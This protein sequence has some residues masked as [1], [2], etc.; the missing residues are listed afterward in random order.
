MRHIALP[1]PGDDEQLKRIAADVME[2]PLDRSRPL[3]E[4]WVI[5]GLSGN[6]FAILTKTHHCMVDGA[7]GM[8]LMEYMFSLSADAE[9][10][11]APRFVP[12]PAP[13]PGV[14]RRAARRRRI[15]RPALLVSDFAAFWRE[16]DDPVG[17]VACRLRSL[18]A[19]ARFKITPASETPINGPT[20]PHRIFDWLELPLEDLKAVRRA[21]GCSINDVVLASVTGAVRELMLGRQVSPEKLEFR[22]SIHSI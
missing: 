5:E 10:R 9:I 18:A 19:L 22:V 7:S 17:E 21:R 3:W 20:G 2:R 4:T 14:L 11:E 1:Q 8:S 13:R 15:S 16:S 6:R 12:R